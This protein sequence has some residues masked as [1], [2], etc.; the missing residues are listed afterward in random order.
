MNSN[1]VE[2]RK[3]YFLR[4]I[5]KCTLSIPLSLNSLELKFVFFAIP[6]VLISTKIGSF[7][8]VDSSNNWNQTVFVSYING[9]CG[10]VWSR[11]V[12]NGFKVDY[13]F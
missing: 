6:L 8:R 9:F 2:I 1:H 11:L 4:I 7:V 3:I 13:S 12:K 10:F 5:K